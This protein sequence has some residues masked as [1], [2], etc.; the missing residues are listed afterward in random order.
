MT[1]SADAF[2]TISEVSEA[3]DTPAHVLRFWESRFPQIKP[4]KRAGGRRYYRPADVALLGG[5]KQLLHEDGLT[6]RGV[7]KILRD[8][9]V[10][11]V[12][13]IEHK[14]TANAT[15]ETPPEAPESPASAAV[16]TTPWPP[17]PAP[18]PAPEAATFPADPEDAMARPSDKADSDDAWPAGTLFDAPP[19]APASTDDAPEAP[20]AVDVPPEPEAAQVIALAPAH[21]V[22]AP[23]T[24]PAADAPA[25]DQIAARLRT[26][27]ARGVNA[28]SA[29][30]LGAFRD[31]IEAHRARLAAPPRQPM[32]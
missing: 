24:A 25:P 13:A 19:K 10:R 28:E 12:A 21:A 11:H 22:P 1:K 17:S 29:A 6:I 7:Q 14:A 18:D 26:L 2:R 16:D 4:V 3:L 20:M 31:R 23:D 8:Q 27:S 9:G 30:L 15:T 32:A 5:I